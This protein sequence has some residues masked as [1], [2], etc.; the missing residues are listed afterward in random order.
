MRKQRA[1]E[2]S[3]T[4]KQRERRAPKLRPARLPA[5]DLE[6]GATAQRL[7]E[8]RVDE[9]HAQ[10][11]VAHDLGRGGVLCR[12]GAEQ[13]G[14]RRRVRARA[15]PE[16]GLALGEADPERVGEVLPARLVGV[17]ERAF[18][19]GPEAVR[20]AFPPAA[21][22][23]VR[24]RRASMFHQ[25]RQIVGRHQHIVVGE[26][27]PLVRGGVPA[28]EAVVE[29]RVGAD[30]LV[31]DQQSGAHAAD[32]RR[33]GAGPSGTTGSRACGDAEDQFIVWII[34]LKTERNV[35]S[36]KLSSAAEWSDQADDRRRRGGAGRLSVA[37][38]QRTIAAAMLA[39]CKPR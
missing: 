17:E 10:S 3:G 33:S 23:R 37:R 5:P 31:A 18:D 4:I 21:S 13:R 25:P 9:A 29:L 6:R 34:E 12:F 26:H 15:S 7:R 14:C 2:I 30:A 11:G 28:L 32:A 16:H 24:C 1:A 38:R 39:M 27:D 22:R 35:G 8:R 19:V 36:T 20:R